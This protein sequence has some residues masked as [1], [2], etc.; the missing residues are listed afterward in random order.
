MSNRDDVAWQTRAVSNLAALAAKDVEGLRA[1]HEAWWDRFFKKSFVEIADKTLEKDYYGSLYFLVSSRLR[2]GV[3]QYVRLA[4][5]QGLT[6]VVVN[7]WPSKTLRVFRAGVDAGTAT[8][9]DI[10][11]PTAK[12]EVLT[13][14]PYGIAWADAVSRMAM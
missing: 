14:V 6:A 5:E 9:T 13:L 1:A 12:G 7:P 4:S 2:A 11:L 8:G 10:T 3:V